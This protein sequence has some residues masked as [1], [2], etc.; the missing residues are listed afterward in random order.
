MFE[1]IGK[2]IKGWAKATFIVETIAAIVAGIV[3]TI[4]AQIIY[5][6]VLKGK[7]AFL[8]LSYFTAPVYAIILAVVGAAVFALIFIVLSI[9][10]LKKNDYLVY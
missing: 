2:K 8:A 3:L 1:N 9:K 10:A 6:I 4:I 5:N 7:Y